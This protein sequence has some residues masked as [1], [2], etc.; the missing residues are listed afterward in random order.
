MS[1]PIPF[2]IDLG[3]GEHMW[4]NASAICVVDKP[5][6]DFLADELEAPV[7]SIDVQDWTQVETNSGSRMIQYP[8]DKFIE[9]W[10]KAIFGAMGD[11]ALLNG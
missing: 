8:M 7:S 9:E 6:A 10:Q 3:D 4:F 1:F 5:D 2:K 11:K